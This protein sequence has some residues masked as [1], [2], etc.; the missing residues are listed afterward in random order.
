MMVWAF[1]YGKISPSLNIYRNLATSN[2]V[3]LYHGS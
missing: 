1:F 3:T 2:L